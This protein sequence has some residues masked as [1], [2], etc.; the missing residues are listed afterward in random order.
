MQILSL[1]YISFKGE[2]PRVTQDTNIWFFKQFSC[3]QDLKQL[4]IVYCRPSGL[5]LRIYER[6]ICIYCYLKSSISNLFLFIALCD[7]NKW[8]NIPPFR[9]NCIIEAIFSKFLLVCNLLFYV[10]K[11]E[12][13]CLKNIKPI[14]MILKMFSFCN[15]K[16][17]GG[18]LCTHINR[19]KTRP[20]MQTGIHLS[21]FWDTVYHVHRASWEMSSCHC[22]CSYCTALRINRARSPMLPIHHIVKMLFYSRSC[23]TLQ[24]LFHI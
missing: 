21:W 20:P 9:E 14:S 18:K 16:Y 2:H 7:A 4:N 22:L 10:L 8:H 17:N 24:Y 15:I 13:T 1:F 12:S 11:E 5:F 3:F 6:G 19:T 23:N